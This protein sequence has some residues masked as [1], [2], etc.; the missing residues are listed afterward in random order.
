MLT[1]KKTHKMGAV[2]DTSSPENLYF[3][4]NKKSNATNIK[5]G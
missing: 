3:C 4:E 1:W 5:K 2:K